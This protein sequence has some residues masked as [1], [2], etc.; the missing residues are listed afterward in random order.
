MKRDAMKRVPW[1][2]WSL[3]IFPLKTDEKQIIAARL[4]TIQYSPSEPAF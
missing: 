4:R 2:K 1:R 3:K